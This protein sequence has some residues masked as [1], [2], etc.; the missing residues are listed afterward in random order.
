MGAVSTPVAA[1][2]WVHPV[3]ITTLAVGAVLLAV[4]FA[5][6]GAEYYRLPLTERPFHPQH[7]TLR[8]AGTIGLR[9]GFAAVVAFAVIYLY[10]LRKR[11]K[12]LQKIGKTRNWLNFHV[13]FGLAVPVIVTFHSS[14]KLRGLAGMAYWIMIAIVLSGIVGRYLYSQIPRNVTAAERSLRDLLE[15]ADALSHELQTQEVF[16]QDELAKLLELPAPEQVAAMALLPAL[17][18][19]ASLDVRRPWHVAALRR[20]VLTG[21]EL[22]FTLGGLRESSHEDLERIIRAARSQSWLTAKL[23][24][25]NRAAEVFHLW[26]VIHRPFSYSFVLL[27]VAHITMVMLMG[28]F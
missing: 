18:T 22:W 14:L 11:I 19:M 3:I 23:L 25:L 24:F 10:P 16:R 17:I 6:Q 8:P 27:V 9:L 4:Y 7:G 21:G 13:L 2:K 28:Y 20:R 12:P 1:R 15:E 26:H 5:L